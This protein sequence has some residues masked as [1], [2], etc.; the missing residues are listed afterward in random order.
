MSGQ[1][2][3]R[4]NPLILLPRSPGLRTRTPARAPDTPHALDGCIMHTKL[5]ILT[6]N[7]ELQEAG[8]RQ[9]SKQ[10]TRTSSKV[11][12]CRWEGT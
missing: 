2:G 11:M 1:P 5:S 12:W 6:R 9:Q 3:L 7:E 10:R 4:L 8:E